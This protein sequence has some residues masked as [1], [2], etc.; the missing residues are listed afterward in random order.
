MAV[1]D[2]PY[3]GQSGIDPWAFYKGYCT[4]FVAWRM[5]Q[6]AGPMSFYNFMGGGHWGDAGN[7]GS[8]AQ[9]LAIPVNSTPAVG[10]IAWWGYGT[11]SPYGH[12]AY[13]ETV[14]ADGTI[15]VEDYNYVRL[16]YDRRVVSLSDPRTR[17]SGFIHF[18][19]VVP[20][21]TPPAITLSCVKDGGVYP[22]AIT[23]EFFAVDTALT[24]LTATLDGV[25]FVSGTLLD[26]PGEHV[27]VVTAID[28]AANTATATARFVIDPDAVGPD[29]AFTTIAGS[30]RYETAVRMSQAAFGS[31]SC[32]VIATGENWPDA[33]GGAA[34]AGA[35]EAPILLTRGG[36]LPPVVLAEIDRLNATS[37][38]ILGGE[39]AVD[40]SVEAVLCELFGDDAVQRIGG[41]DRYE[42]AEMI[43]REVVAVSDDA[44]DGTCLI[45]TG[46]DF[47]DAL[48]ASPLSAARRWPLLLTAPNGLSGPTVLVLSEIGVTRALV[49]GGTSVVPESVETSL[50]AQLGPAEGSVVRLNGADR[51]TTAAAVAAYAADEGMS[52][53]RAAVATGQDF[54]DALAGGVSQARTGSVMLLTNS[55]TLS[56]PARDALVA[57]RAAISSL[58][59]LGGN[60][61]V[62]PAVKS[63][64]AQALE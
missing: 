1:D 57:N 39:G 44:Y 37:A 34:L 8:N 32:V 40:P 58:R 35:Y 18:H 24:S 54:P 11:I 47:P 41:A 9:K 46:T 5:N 19:D 25:P 10:A 31:A 55:T 45:A 7:W 14:N 6:N 20:D 38:V 64:L 59:Y 26:V 21:T 56:A 49:L 36:S 17:P 12:V 27:L 13:V 28:A 16:A 30:D 61:A 60:A 22:S 51:Y 50:A 4:S 62:C 42:T 33:L 43:A 63:A 29:V 52:W 23:P 3:R 15:T 53:D 48:A 2:Y